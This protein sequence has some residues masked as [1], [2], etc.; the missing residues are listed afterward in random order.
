MMAAAPASRWTDSDGTPLTCREKLKV[1]DGNLD[2]LTQ[3]CRDALDDALLMG[4][5]AEAYKAALQQMINDLQPTV[6][7]RP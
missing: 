3:Q 4:C 1:L 2:E 5:S 6:K 7:E